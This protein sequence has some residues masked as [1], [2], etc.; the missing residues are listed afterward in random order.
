MKLPGFLTPLGL[1]LAAAALFLVA[2][3]TIIDG[4][5]NFSPGPL[6][7]A[8][9]TGSLRGG[10]SS[11]AE[12]G[13]NCAGCHTDPWSSQ[14]MNDRC[15]TCH[16]DIQA[17]LSDPSSLHG[18]LEAK[19]CR[20]CHI[21]HQGAQGY[22]VQVARLEIDHNK[23]GFSLATHR[24]TAKSIPLA[25]GDCHTDRLTRFE[26]AQCETCH[27]SNND[28]FVTSHVSEFGSDCQACH[29]G[30]DIFTKSKFDH[31]Q[32]IYPLLGKHANAKCVDCHAGVRNL[33]DFKVAPTDCVSCHREDNK[34]TANFGTEC[35][36]CHNSEGWK[37]EIFDHNLS[38]YKLTGK[39]IQ[40]A[41]AQCHVNNTFKGTP[42]KC[43]SCHAQDDVHLG[44][45]STDCEACHNTDTWKRGSFQHTFPLDHGGR[46]MIACATCHTTPANYQ[47]YTCY[48]CHNPED[49]RRYHAF[50]QMMNTDITNCARCHPTGQK[51]SRM[52]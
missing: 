30:T 9:R 38:V 41:C 52:H 51:T 1:Q 25:C 42:T 40:V 4:G 37:T 44:R 34:H 22:L 36:R 33:S 29:D 17:E 43:V 8:N 31:N 7:A 11:H 10:V 3:I 19:N 24:I 50:A 12:L 49:I 48:N 18:V 26:P 13:A 20:E 45:F 14:S 47:A 32:L 15:A 6:S 23:F 27:R 2:L 16:T 46:G 35:A 28:L 5:S 21:E 39:H